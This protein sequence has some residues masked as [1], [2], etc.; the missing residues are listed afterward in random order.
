MSRPDTDPHDTRLTEHHRVVIVG[1]GQ[2]GITVASRLRHAGIDDIAIVE[3]ATEHYYQPLWTLVGGGLVDVAKSARPEA[4]VIPRKARWIRDRCTAVNPDARVV[5]TDGGSRIGYDLLVMAA[6]IQLDWHAIAGMAEAVASPAVS[7]N[8]DVRLAPKTWQ[9]MRDLRR[10]TALFTMPA[11]PIKCPGAP[12]KIAYLCADHWRRRGVLGDIRV[13]LVLPGPEL[14]GIP[15]YAAVLAQAVERYGIEVRFNT[16]VVSFDAAAR[17]V[18]LLDTRTGVKDTL[19]YDVA[20][21]TPPQSA[22]DWVKS[23]PLA[24]P[25]NQRGFIDVDEHTLRHTRYPSVFALGDVADTPNAKTGA[26]VRRQ[27]PVVAAGVLATLAGRQ[28]TGHYDGYA[29]CPFTTARNRV[30][31]A[32]FDYSMTARRSVPILDTAR[33]RYSM[34]LL[35]RHG[36]PAAYWTL[37]LRGLA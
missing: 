2:G 26:A 5:T 1:G 19:D 13:V 10:G 20:H 9:I 6:G 29:A 11:G 7:S 35:T 37:F 28:P 27:A 32:E 15:A 8:Y 34:W 36:L 25:G 12:Q 21:V 31:L 16:E 22:P 3:P 33:E 18:T 14:F 4:S 23:S 17:R 30:L 24:Q